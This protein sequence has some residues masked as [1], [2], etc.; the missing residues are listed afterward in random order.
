MHSGSNTRRRNN[1]CSKIR[2]K[3]DA[4]KRA[5]CGRLR[6]IADACHPAQIAAASREPQRAWWRRRL[7]VAQAGAKPGGDGQMNEGWI[8]VASL[9]EVAD[10]EMLQVEVGG[11]PVC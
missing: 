4:P 5:G 3:S 6:T 2:H 1:I 7:P 11:E 8:T 9:D 10:G